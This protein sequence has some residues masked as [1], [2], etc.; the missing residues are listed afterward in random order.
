M[1]LSHDLSNSTVL[2]V[3]NI[4][5]ET[6]GYL[7]DLFKSDGFKIEHLR[8]WQDRIPALSKKYAAIVILGGP[9]SVYDNVD[10]L[11]LEQSLIRDAMQNNVATLGICLGSQLIAQ[12]AGGRVY[13]GLRKEIG[14]YDDIQVTIAGRKDLFAGILSRLKVFQWHGDTYALPIDA[15]VL[16]RSKLYPQAFRIGTAVGVQFHL[17]VSLQM[18]ESWIR[19]YRAELASEKKRPEDIKPKN[20]KEIHDLSALCEK[21]YFNFRKNISLQE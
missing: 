18:I 8:A 1:H 9:M 10:F 14:W 17:E 2:S 20:R 16:A 6:L 7:E 19:E 15:K 21:V 11:G 13:P 4:K 3:Q 5:Y 12:A